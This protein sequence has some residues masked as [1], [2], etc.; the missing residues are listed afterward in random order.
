MA[1]NHYAST[2]P[3]R[4]SMTGQSVMEA[5]SPSPL[6]YPAYR[7]FWIARF[8]AVMATTSVVVILGYQLVVIAIEQYGMNQRQ[9]GFQLGLLGLAQ[10]IPLFVLTPVAGW[11]A[12]R[13]DRRNV[14]RLANSIDMLVALVLGWLTWNGMLTLPLIFVMSA[15][16]GTARVFVG[17]SMS[18][19]VANILPA[20]SLPRAIAL[21][22]IAWQ[23]A[24]VIGPASAGF[25]FAA[26]PSAPYWVAGALLAIASIAVSFL[27]P[28]KVPHD[29]E[30]PHPVRQMIDGVTYCWNERFLLGAISLD[31]FAVL[32]GGATAMLPLFAYTVLNVGA[33]GLGWMRAAPALGAAALALWFAWRPLARNVGVKML[34]AVVVFGVATIGF[35]LSSSL[36][37]SLA[38]L[39][40]LGAADMLS[41]Y[42]RSSLVQLNT[43]DAMRGR[44]SSVS[45]LA[46]SASNELGEMQSGLAA[47]ALGPVGAVVFGG[48][49]AILVTGLWAWLF[50][51]LRNAKTFEP[52]FKDQKT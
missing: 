33:E 3:D 50:P 48:V 49:G 18:A 5:T 31:L 29:G 16:H 20:A 45:T 26:N 42:V 8:A 37:L 21:N 6:S 22:S 19:M 52:Q 38:L 17:P 7:L 4:R 35:G 39:A 41:V 1:S 43:P 34:W 40:L 27:P 14:A 30:R 15:L 32:L 25:L 9:A 10:F 13:F 47:A 2:G 24:S 46:V 51:E 28:I 23:S 12:D 36:P 44:V 11:A